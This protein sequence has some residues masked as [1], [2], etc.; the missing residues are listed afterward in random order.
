MRNWPWL[1]VAGALLTGLGLG[2]ALE[3]ARARAAGSPS[4][5]SDTELGAMAPGELGSRLMARIG[6]KFVASTGWH[7]GVTFYDQPKPYGS[8][9]CRVN[10]YSV[11]KKVAT[12]RLEQRQDWWADDLDVER[13]Y[14]VWRRPSAPDTPDAARHKACAAFRDFGNTFTSHGVEAAEPERAAFLLEAVIMAA[15]ASGKPTFALTCRRRGM[16]DVEGPPCD[17]RA[18]VRGL[19]LQRL[20]R[21]ETLSFVH[22]QEFGASRDALSL[23]VDA[24]AG[25][26]VLLTLTIASEQRWGRHSISE[27]EVKSVEVEIEELH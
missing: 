2:V 26:P 4:D 21:S 10:A 1:Y 14:G 25:K 15:R 24:P 8:W 18:I 13:R 23:E 27:G 17:G 5:L 19:S 3:L 9:S 11:P 6:R 16:H 12:G 20:R 7:G 22:G